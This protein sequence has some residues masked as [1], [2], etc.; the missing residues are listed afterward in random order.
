MTFTP[1]LP[2]TSQERRG[3]GH[4]EASEGAVIQGVADCDLEG[5]D[6]AVTPDQKA[7]LSLPLGDMGCR[8][9]SYQQNSL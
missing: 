7:A 6:E 8:S 3:P 2:A 5:S 9:G 4:L 1:S